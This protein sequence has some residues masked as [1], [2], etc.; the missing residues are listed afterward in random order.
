[1]TRGG[2]SAD[3]SSQDST[4]TADEVMHTHPHTLIHMPTE[5]SVMK[6]PLVQINISGKSGVFIVDSGATTQPL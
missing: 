1:M 2:A 6:L 5:E 3:M 4:P